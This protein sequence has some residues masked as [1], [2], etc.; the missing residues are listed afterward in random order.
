[1]NLFEQMESFDKKRNPVFTAI[2]KLKRPE[3]IQRFVSEYEEWLVKNGD[4]SIKGRE[5]ETA[6]SNVG[7]ILGYYS[8]ETM[9]LWYANLPDVNHPVFGSGF[10][11]GKEVTPEEA[12]AKG[13]EMGKKLKENER[14]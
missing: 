7:Y 6:R 10:G 2:E 5:R 14:K 13:I 12:F 8:D 3:D 4:A 11:R 9:K 1:M